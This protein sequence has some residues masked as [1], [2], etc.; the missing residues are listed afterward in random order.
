MKNPGSDAHEA[1]KE[2]VLDKKLLK[3]IKKAHQVLSHR[4]ARSVS[5]TCHKV[6]S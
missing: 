5:L 1:L 6:L 4:H 3:D 2:V